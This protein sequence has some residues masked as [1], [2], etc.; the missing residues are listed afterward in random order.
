LYVSDGTALGTVMVD[1]VP[2][3]GSS[4]P[5]DMVAT[6]NGVCFYA[7][8]GLGAEPWF[9][10]G[11]AANTFRICD[12]APGSGSS[13]PQQFTVAHGRVFFTASDPATGN[14]LHEI[15]TPGAVARRL[16]SG[17]L[18]SLPSLDSRDARAPVL[19]TT[20][21]IDATGPGGSFG[22]L[23]GGLSA[24]PAPAPA[25]LTLGAC[26]WVGLTAGTALVLASSAQPTI[27]FPFAV[28]NQIGLTGVAVHLQ[29]LW[30]SPA[31]SPP[32]EPSNGLQLV[33]GGPVA[34]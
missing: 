28:P 34:Q 12:L 2:G 10:D 15:T 9:S 25:G 31:Q 22:F 14:E 29:A 5:Q 27:S 20:I 18:P 24:L 30:L 1:I 17:A 4:Y 16:G 26:D 21:D 11:T 6:G 33:L 3:S 7:T 8:D 32:L 19:G 13:T 23:L